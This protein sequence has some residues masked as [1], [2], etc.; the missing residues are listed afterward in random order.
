ML[1]NFAAEE[2]A[3]KEMQN[4]L[5]EDKG[6]MFWSGWGSEGTAEKVREIGLEVVVQ[7]TVEVM[8]NV[9]FLWVLARKSNS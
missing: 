3:G 6:W 7:E 5:D 4:W 2:L 8:V 9:K 1:A